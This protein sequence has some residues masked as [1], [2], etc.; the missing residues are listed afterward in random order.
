MQSA[1]TKGSV[2]LR[3]ASGIWPDV[4]GKLLRW[5]EGNVPVKSRCGPA[6]QLLDLASI[7]DTELGEPDAQWFMENPDVLVRSA[8]AYGLCYTGWSASRAAPAYVRAADTDFASPWRIVVQ[9]DGSE[10]VA[11]ALPVHLSEPLFNYYETD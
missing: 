9:P 4:A 1:G 3:P 10:D 7:P 2:L 8:D 6:L 5:P 11:S